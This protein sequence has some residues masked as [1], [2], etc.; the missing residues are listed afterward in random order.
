MGLGR[1]PRTYFLRSGEGITPSLPGAARRTTATPTWRWRPAPRST[2]SRSSACSRGRRYRFSLRARS[3]DADAQLSVPVCEKWMLY[4]RRCIW[5]TL[6]IGDTGGEWRTF[7]AASPAAR[8]ARRGAHARAR[9]SC[10]CSA[11]PKAAR[12]TSTMCR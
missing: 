4:S 3:R 7:P 6:W 11:R 2:S 1:Y 10:R 5:H 12:S 8:S 9:S